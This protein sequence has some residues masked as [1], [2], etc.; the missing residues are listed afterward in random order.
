MHVQT[1][2]IREMIPCL[3]TLLKELL[4]DKEYKGN[5][6]YL[7]QNGCDFVRNNS[8]V[9]FAKETRYRVDK[10]DY[11]D[12]AVTEALV[13]AL[14]H[15]NYIIMDSEIH[16]DMYDDR[17]E[18]QSPGGMFEGKPIQE[19]DISSIGS[20]RRNPIIADLFHRMKYMERRGS[21]LKK[22]ISETEKLPGYTK[23]LAPEFF[24]T[25][26]DFRVVLKN[27]NYNLSGA[28]I[29]DTTQDT[30]QDTT[31]NKMLDVISYC[32][33]ARTREEIQA[34]IGIAN[35]SHF[36]KAYLKPLLENGQLK[37]TIPDKPNSKNQKYIA[38]QQ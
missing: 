31:K 15:R 19:C 16:I 38:S 29:Q 35:R 5:L 7:L 27:I 30:I 11:A 8:K 13:N 28:T 10:P 1:I 25:P 4:D 21:G 17:L 34:H 14:I 6:I 2:D 23:Q 3:L 12:R 22:I 20:V 18:I 33:E 9:R 37:M 26:S 24:S 32:S 36:R